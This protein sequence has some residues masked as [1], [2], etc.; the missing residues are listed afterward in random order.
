VLSRGNGRQNIFFPD[1]DQHAF[2]DRLEQVSERFG[3][4]IC[5]YVLMDNHYHLL[6]KTPEAN[7]SKAMQ[8]IGTT[9][10]RR[11]HIHNHSSGHLFQGRHKSIIVENKAYL[12]RLSCYIHRNPLRV[13]LVDRLIDYPWSSH[14]YFA[15]KE[16]PPHWLWVVTKEGTPNTS[17]LNHKAFDPISQW[18]LN[19]KERQETNLTKAIRKSSRRL[20]ELWAL[21]GAPIS[22]FKIKMFLILQHK[23]D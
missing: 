11:F 10:T 8:W 18:G 22:L 7:L 20:G 15:D 17:R 21:W 5:A 1:K 9:S 19:K 23:G 3:T 12:L 2:L 16:K 13:K 14:R 4:V 6:V